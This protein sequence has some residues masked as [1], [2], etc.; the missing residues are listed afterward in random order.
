MSLLHMNIYGS[1]LIAF[2]VIIRI[3]GINKLP[4]RTFIIL[5]LIAISRLLIPYTLPSMINIYPVVETLNEQIQILRPEQNEFIPL[6]SPNILESDLQII[7][8][9]EPANNIADLEEKPNISIY[10]G[11]WI[12]GL[13]SFGVLFIIPYVLNSKKYK[14]ALPVKNDYIDSWVSSHKLRRKYK[15][16]VS[17]EILSPFTYGLFNSVI[18]LPESIDLNNHELIDYILTH[19]YIHIKRFDII[20]KWLS[21]ITLCVNLYNPF[22]WIMYIFMNRDIE[23]ACDEKVIRLK[24]ETNKKSYAKMLLNFEINMINFNPLVNYFN[25]NPLKE[26]ITSI[27]KIKKTT[28]LSIILA[29]LL[30]M[31]STLILISSCTNEENAE[32]IDINIKNEI[33]AEEVDPYTNVRFGKSPNTLLLDVEWY[34]YDTYFDEIKKIKAKEYKF[35]EEYIKLSDK[36]KNYVDTQLDEYIVIMEENLNLIKDNKL[37][38]PRF[39]NGKERLIGFQR[40]ESEISQYL[41]SDGYFIWYVYPYNP[42]IR[43]NDE[44]GIPQYKY[45]YYYEDDVAVYSKREYNTLLQEEIIPF[46]DDLLARGLI[47]QEYYD[48]HTIKDPLD[49]FVKAFFN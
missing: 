14:S 39:I 21:A 47:N 17:D 22:V 10:S 28:I 20:L 26:R 48:N 25:K 31:S 12:V 13:F 19:E 34:T 46:C 3:F 5:W 16:M 32:P 33:K 42:Y 4:K 18:L 6:N 27:L 24:G 41:D 8:E 36:D 23:L 29:F 9:E 40:D 2:T 43:Y 35:D 45:F 49:F 15:V 30:I 44:N 1:L 11:I 38:I 37:Y 7:N